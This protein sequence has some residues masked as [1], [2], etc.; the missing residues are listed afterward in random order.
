[1]SPGFSR[2]IIIYNFC[3]LLLSMVMPVTLLCREK[4]SGVMLDVVE[5]YM[6]DRRR[7]EAGHIQYA[8]LRVVSWYPEILAT[9]KL[10]LHAN[11]DET[12]ST[13]VSLYH[14]AFMAHNAR[15][16][17]INCHAKNLAIS[18]DLCYVHNIKN[19]H[20]SVSG[21]GSTLVLDGNMKNHRDVCA[22]KEAR[23]AEFN[24]L[25]GMVKTGCP[26]TPQLKSRYCLD[27]TPTSFKSNPAS[28][29][30]DSPPTAT[31]TS[32]SEDVQLAYIV[33]KQETRQTTLYQVQIA[34]TCM[35]WC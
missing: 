9:E 14:G 15:K 16:T 33:G 7:A 12:L 23:Y 18:C 5:R 8:I 1:M 26:N 22:A 21:C 28:N 10:T 17:K 20:C 31:S 25:P 24:G 2:V 34:I 27:H 3:V 13:V 35:C 6:L 11:T 30:A 29:D 32:H 4:V 19:R